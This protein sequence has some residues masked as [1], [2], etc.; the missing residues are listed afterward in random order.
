MEYHLGTPVSEFEQNFTENMEEK[1]IIVT[2][3]RIAVINTEYEKLQLKL[4]EVVSNFYDKHNKPYKA[5]N[6]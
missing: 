5:N 4:S 6:T 3:K 1:N 2:N